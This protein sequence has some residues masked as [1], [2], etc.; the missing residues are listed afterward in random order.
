M[1]EKH[2]IEG[3]CAGID[4]VYPEC[5]VADKCCYIPLVRIETRR[6]KLMPEEIARYKA[7]LEAEGKPFYDGWDEVIDEAEFACEE[8]RFEVG[9]KYRITIEEIV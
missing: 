8:F 5:S 4:K 6:E 9:K 1:S 3:P 2:V 7:E